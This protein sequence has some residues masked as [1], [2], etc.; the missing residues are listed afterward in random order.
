MILSKFLVE[1]ALE[2]DSVSTWKCMA[3]DNIFNHVQTQDFFICLFNFASQA[4]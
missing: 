3:A 1:L 4:W 2:S